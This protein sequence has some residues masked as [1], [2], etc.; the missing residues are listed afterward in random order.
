MRTL[1][2]FAHGTPKAQP[3]VRAFKRGNHAGVFDPGT[4]DGW[5]F[6]I[7]AACKEKWDGVQFTGPL[8]VDA[9]FYFERPKCH[10]RANGA[11]RD[12]APRFH[13]QKPDRDNLEKA[14]LDALTG[15]GV[16][17]DDSQVCDGR[18]SKT[19]CHQSFGFAHLAFPTAGVHVR[20]SEVVE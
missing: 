17:K 5:K 2:F 6:T 3:R 19:W 15:L 1:E 11:V 12:A 10:L 14:L 18:V 9:V 7:R 20:I 16:F 8:R 4:A 13:I